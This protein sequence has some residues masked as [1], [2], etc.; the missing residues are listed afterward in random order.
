[1]KSGIVGLIE[2]LKG[3]GIALPTTYGLHTLHVS[4]TQLASP[5][6][7]LVYGLQIQVLLPLTVHLCL[8]VRTSIMYINDNGMHWLL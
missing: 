8:V 6:D 4:V 7:G 1:M 3:G 2:D 5:D